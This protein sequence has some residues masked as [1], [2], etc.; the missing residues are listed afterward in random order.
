M[1]LSR[2]PNYLVYIT[3]LYYFFQPNL[4]RTFSFCRIIEKLKA[5]GKS[6]AEVKAFMAAA[7]AFVK[8]VCSDFKEWQFFQGTLPTATYKHTVPLCHHPTPC[9]LKPITT[10]FLQIPWLLFN[11]LYFSLKS[12]RRIDER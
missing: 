12:F 11:S 2:V 7:S 4:S 6:E 1:G 9:H 10:H 3:T 5:A 8:K